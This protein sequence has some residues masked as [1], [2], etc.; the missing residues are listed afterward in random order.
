MN[1]GMMGKLVVANVLGP[2]GKAAPA[3][4]HVH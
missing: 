4:Q 2:D 3:V 1:S